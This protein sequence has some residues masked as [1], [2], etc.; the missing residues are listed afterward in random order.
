M[1]ENASRFA[2]ALYDQF[3]EDHP[4]A[5]W[6]GDELFTRMPQPPALDTAPAPRFRPSQA[7][8]ETAAEPSSR[9][10]ERPLALVD[11]PADRRRAEP[12]REWT[13]PRDRRRGSLAEARTAEAAML[14]RAERLGLSVVEGSSAHRWDESGSMI[15]PPPEGRQTKVIT[16]H[17]GTAPR[18]YAA[19]GPE[20]RRPARTPAEWIGPRPD[21][22]VA[23]AFVLGLVLILIAIFTA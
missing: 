19:V 12:G 7:A 2:A 20:R 17:P 18:P 13:G 16:G 3:E 9:A 6:G 1:P 22:L 23:W 21:R 5:D 10:Q 11:P 15:E 8:S 14:A 4:V